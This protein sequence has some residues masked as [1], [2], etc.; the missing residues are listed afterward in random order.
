LKRTAKTLRRRPRAGGAKIADLKRWVEQDFGRKFKSVARVVESRRGYIHF[1]MWGPTL[2]YSIT[3]HQVGAKNPDGRPLPAD[4]LGCAVT[5]RCMFDGEDWNRGGDYPDGPLK[6]TI[7][8]QIA[9]AIRADA[10]RTLPDEESET[11]RFMTKGT[12]KDAVAMKMKVSFSPTLK[13]VEEALER[14]K[15]KRAKKKAM[16]LPKRARTKGKR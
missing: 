12:V 3:A 1:K 5:S 10:I 15:A 6:K 13:G 9:K 14:K 8:D 7:W 4:Y 2:I 11:W 16:P